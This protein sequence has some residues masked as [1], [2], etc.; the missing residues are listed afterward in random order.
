MVSTYVG[1]L[2]CKNQTLKILMYITYIHTSRP[3]ER[4]IHS[5]S[6]YIPHYLRKQQSVYILHV[7][8]LTL[9]PFSTYCFAHNTEFGIIQRERE[10]EKREPLENANL[11]Q[12]KQIYLPIYDKS[13]L[14]RTI[15]KHSHD[16]S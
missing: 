6:N 7:R 5:F 9:G 2:S 15:V 3:L 1:Y 16:T 13:S 4:H 12:G 11:L 8:V 10:K 14:R